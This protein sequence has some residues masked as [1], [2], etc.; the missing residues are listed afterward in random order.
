M[1]KK[2]QDAAKLAKDLAT[3]VRHDVENRNATALALSAAQP[4]LIFALDATE[5]RVSTWSMAGELQHDMLTAAGNAG[6]AVAI[7]YFNNQYCGVTNNYF[8]D[9]QAASAYLR[10]IRLISCYTKIAQ[11][12]AQFVVH[13]DSPHGARV[14]IFIGD[15]FEDDRAATLLQAA[16]LKERGFR[17]FML[18]EGQNGNAEQNFR[19]VA[20]A[21]GGLFARFDNGSKVQLQELVQSIASYAAGNLALTHHGSTFATALKALPPPR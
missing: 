11:L 12:F 9:A 18:L 8:T 3:A 21:T 20:E 7:G 17:V 1:F 10:S 5:S 14:A 2:L 13:A 16:K 6:L 15:S 4:K 19:A